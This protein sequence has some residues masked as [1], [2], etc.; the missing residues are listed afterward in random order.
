[1][2]S[3]RFTTSL[4]S[5]LLIECVQP[6]CSFVQR[7]VLSS[8]VVRFVIEAIGMC[9]VSQK[10]AGPLADKE[11]P[12]SQV[13]NRFS[14]VIERIE[15]LYKVMYI[16]LVLSNWDRVTGIEQ[17]ESQLYLILVAKRLN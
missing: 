12:L 1:M 6:A 8:F 10:N 13:P 17:V 9:F 14:S 4:C 11:D 2:H 7:Q 5:F 16:L 15:R 3:L